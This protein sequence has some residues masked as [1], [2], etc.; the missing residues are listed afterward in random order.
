LFAWIINISFYTG[1][2]LPRLTLLAFVREIP[3]SIGTNKNNVLKK[4]SKKE[5]LL[6]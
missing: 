5:G 2:D 6:D 1:V 4:K 3:E